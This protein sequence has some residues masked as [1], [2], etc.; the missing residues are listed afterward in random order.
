MLANQVRIGNWVEILGNSRRLDFF[1]TIQPSSFSVNIDKDYKAIP[2]DEEW[3]LDFG[4]KRE[5]EIGEFIDGPVYCFYY[6]EYRILIDSNFE[7][8]NGIFTQRID[9]VHQLQNLVY[10]L[11]GTELV[12]KNNKN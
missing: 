4:F 8:Y 11:T 5:P 6:P 1:T 12:Y 7:F 10:A 3:L 9:F 2:L